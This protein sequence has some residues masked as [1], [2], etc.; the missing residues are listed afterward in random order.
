MVSC[1]EAPWGRSA[2]VAL[3]GELGAPRAPAVEVGAAGPG[4]QWVLAGSSGWAGKEGWR[5][6]GLKSQDPT[7]GPDGR[8]GP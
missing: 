1:G 8:Q 7:Q 2:L 4:G 6:S 5:E 3:Q